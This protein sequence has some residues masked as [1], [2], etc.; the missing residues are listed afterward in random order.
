[1][2]KYGDCQYTLNNRKV[3]KKYIATMAESYGIET[4]NLCQFLAQDTVREF[5]SLS[6][7]MIFRGKTFILKM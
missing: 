4:G 5:P 3:G 2:S 7:Q 1:M 6:P